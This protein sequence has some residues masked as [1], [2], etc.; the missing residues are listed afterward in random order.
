M[1]CIAESTAFKT[2]S[3]SIKWCGRADTLESRLRGMMK[4]A[5]EAGD[6]RESQL[7]SAVLG[8][9]SFTSDESALNETVTRLYDEAAIATLIGNDAFEESSDEEDEGEAEEE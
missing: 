1:W 9:G 3:P 7:E 6:G 8:K 4:E 2:C 5:H